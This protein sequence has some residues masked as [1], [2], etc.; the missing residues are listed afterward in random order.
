MQSLVKRLQD[1]GVLAPPKYGI[2]PALGGKQGD[3][4]TPQGIASMN[5]VNGA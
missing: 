5:N 2:H 1:C 4:A 3:L